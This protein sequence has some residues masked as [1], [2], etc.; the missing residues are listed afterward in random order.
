M[1]F[2][3]FTLV[4]RCLI[5]LVSMASQQQDMLLTLA[6]QTQ[7]IDLIILQKQRK[8][9][10]LGSRSLETTKTAKSSL[11]FNLRNELQGYT[12]RF[13]CLR[14]LPSTFDE[15]VGLVRPF[16]VRK[17]SISFSFFPTS[18]IMAKQFSH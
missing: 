14:I 6:L 1:L 17:G 8:V 2:F 15:L 3:Q 11:Q 9:T 18:V 5:F 4:K 10:I 7:V 16:V 13:N 12:M